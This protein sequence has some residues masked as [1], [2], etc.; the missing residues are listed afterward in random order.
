MHLDC[1]IEKI[2]PRYDIEESD[3]HRKLADKYGLAP[4]S[5]SDI[6]AFLDDERHERFN[7]LIDA[8]FPDHVLLELLSDFET[9]NDINIRRLVTDNA[10]VPTIFEYIVG[11]V[12][13]KVSNRKGRILDYFNLSLDADLLP[14]T[15]AA[16][17]M[18]DIT[19][20]YNATPRLPG[21]HTAYRSDPCRGQRTTPHGDGTGLPAFGRLSLT[22]QSAGSLRLV[23]HPF[24]ASKRYFG[25]PGAETFAIFTAKPNMKE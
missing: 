13:Y 6:R 7:R 8:R 16:G 3:L 18:E 4:Q 10:D 12:W 15:H 20:R 24:P 22:R 21:A 11:I 2:I 14:K 9:R 17:G 23:C 19:Y 1:D 25:F 5:L